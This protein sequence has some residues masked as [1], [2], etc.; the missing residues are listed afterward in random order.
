[1]VDGALGP[2]MFGDW[3]K[4]EETS[5]RGER[6]IFALL[7]QRPDFNPFQREPET[8]NVDKR[9]HHTLPLDLHME[10]DE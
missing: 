5:K 1:M 3:K 4:E 6:K 7:G 8:E 9:A 2:P 10:H